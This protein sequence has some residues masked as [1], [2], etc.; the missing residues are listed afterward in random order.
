MLGI[1]RFASPTDSEYPISESAL[2]FYKNA[3]TFPNRYLPFWM[4][5]YARRMVAVVETVIA[6][7]LP[8]FSYAPTVT[9]GSSTNA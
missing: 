5:N 2:V 4:I 8:L 1:P 3:P 9:N 7:V 6:I